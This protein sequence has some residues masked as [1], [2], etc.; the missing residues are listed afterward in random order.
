MRCTYM[1]NQTPLAV[2]LW[3][4][5]I[6]DGDETLFLAKNL[7]AVCR[8]I[9]HLVDDHRQNQ[10][11]LPRG[12]ADCIFQGQT[13]WGKNSNDMELFSEDLNA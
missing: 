5:S 10:P 1:A 13:T 8:P 12:M 4:P 6:Y 9:F 2:H 3:L 7:E 11:S